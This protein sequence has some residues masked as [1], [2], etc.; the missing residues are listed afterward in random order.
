MLLLHALKF[1]LLGTASETF[2][3]RSSY[4]TVFDRVRQAIGTG[5]Y[6][7]PKFITAVD[8]DIT[9]H[10]PHPFHRAVRTRFLLSCFPHV[11]YCFAPDGPPDREVRR[12]DE[13]TGH[14]EWQRLPPP[15]F[16]RTCSA[17]CSCLHQA[18]H[19]H[20]PHLLPPR[21]TPSYRPRAVPCLAPR[22]KGAI[23]K[24]PTQPR[25]FSHPFT[26]ESNS[27]GLRALASVSARFQVDC[28]GLL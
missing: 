18:R 8:Y 25:V 15:S 16:L 23:T 5:L 26:S 9:A 3:S 19:G 21:P 20:S 13:A 4:C 27:D 10:A 28:P 2:F 7:V 14:E 11:L 22:L 24:G 12:K 17:T 1:Q 6:A